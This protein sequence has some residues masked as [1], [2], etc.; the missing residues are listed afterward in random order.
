MKTRV[1]QG[2]RLDFS[3]KKNLRECHDAGQ[4]SYG[5]EM[6]KEKWSFPP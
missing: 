2:N 3:G 5:W 1:L 4:P 6:A